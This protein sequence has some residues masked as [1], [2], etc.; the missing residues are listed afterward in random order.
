MENSVGSSAANHTGNL[1]GHNV[2]PPTG[3]EEKPVRR[4]P[5]RS[6]QLNIKRFE[7]QAVEEKPA[8]SPRVL[9]VKSRS[10]PLIEKLQANLALTPTALLH[11][12]KSPEVNHP[13]SPFSPGPAHSPL[14]PPSPALVSAEQAP[15]SFEEPPEGAVL[16][17]INKGRA[18]LSLKRRP[19]TRQHRK[20][21][22][23]EEG[24]AGG[25]DGLPRSEGD[26]D[27]GESAG[28]EDEALGA[29][30]PSGSDAGGERPAGAPGA[31]EDRQETAPLTQE[32]RSTGDKAA[33]EP[34]GAGLPGEPCAGDRARANQRDGAESQ[35]QEEEEK[36]GESAI[37]PDEVTIEFSVK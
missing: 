19:P 35:P 27:A 20:S 26:Q 29:R 14:P 8:V 21:C 7:E 31:D 37:G 4:R 3:T 1:K 32:V 25:A 17:S 11:S 23:E 15:I 9:T 2:L 12:P 33:A 10:S 18:R 13:P 28:R 22:G 30:K 34:E 6:L 16:P 5:P 36:E 24:A